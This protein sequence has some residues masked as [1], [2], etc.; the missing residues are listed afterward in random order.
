MMRQR[1]LS[2]MIA[3]PAIAAAAITLSA[4]GSDDVAGTASDPVRGASQAALVCPN[5]G[6]SASALMLDNRLGVDLAFRASGVDCANWSETGNPTT[7]NGRAFGDWNKVVQWGLQPANGA[8]PTFVA[9]FVTSP[10]GTPVATLQ[11]KLWQVQVQEG[12]S[13]WQ[14]GSIQTRTDYGGAWKTNASYAVGALNG[15]S[16]RVVT[17]VVQNPGD[18][19][20]DSP[21]GAG[22]A[23]RAWFMRFQF[24]N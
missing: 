13:N 10:E 4:C 3:V 11:V 14:P 23:P 22:A 9:S 7:Y 19:S 21:N 17:G 6:S 20:W 8:N 24:V 16:V 1:L 2:T 5:I 18:G 12:P 15:K